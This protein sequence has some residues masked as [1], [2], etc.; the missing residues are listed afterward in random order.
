[1]LLWNLPTRS[2]ALPTITFALVVLV[3]AVAPTTAL[4]QSDYM[5]LSTWKTSRPCLL[6][7]RIAPIL[8][9]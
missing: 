2:R 8:R 4:L 3:F 6:E 9:S 7:A 1:M 5:K